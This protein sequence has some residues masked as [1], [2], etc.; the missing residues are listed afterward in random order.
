MNG[1]S[2]R[3]IDDAQCSHDLFDLTVKRIDGAVLEEKTTI[4][5]GEFLEQGGIV[6]D[7]N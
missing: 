3:T 5:G 2:L 4:F 6:G 7:T 1:S